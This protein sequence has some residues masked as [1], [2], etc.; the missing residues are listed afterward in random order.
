MNEVKGRLEVN[1]LPS[2]AYLVLTSE[3]GSSRE[4]DILLKSV[5]RPLP[6]CLISEWLL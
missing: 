1:L 6:S 2:W 4:G 5:P 3:C